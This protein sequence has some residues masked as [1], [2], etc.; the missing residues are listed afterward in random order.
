MTISPSLTDLARQGNSEA[1]S[2]LLQ[3]SEPDL[4]RF[5]AR[6]C[7]SS[8]DADDAVSHAMTAIAFK[9]EGFHGLSRLSTWLFTVIRNECAKYERRARRW[10]FGVAESLTDRGATPE[11]VLGR[12]QLLDR[13]VD[14]VRALPVELREVFVLR[15]FEQLGVEACAARLGISEANVK[16]RLHRARA[17]LREALGELR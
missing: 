5:A 14:A 13:I 17:A 15:E 6:V 2:L 3:D 16:V 9:L 10:V 1:L 8:A 12:A 11:Q 7:R 4:R